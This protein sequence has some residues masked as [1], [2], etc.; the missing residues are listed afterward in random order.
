MQFCIEACI[1]LSWSVRRLLRNKRLWHTLGNGR[2]TLCAKMGGCCSRK[3]APQFRGREEVMAFVL[4]E[5]RQQGLELIEYEEAMN[6]DDWHALR[7]RPALRELAP[8]DDK[9]ANQE[10]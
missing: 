1:K 6:Q 8:E 10:I 2:R 7:L 3:Q 4:G 5:M 9:S